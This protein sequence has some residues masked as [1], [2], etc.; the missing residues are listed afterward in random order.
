MQ[1]F[2]KLHIILDKINSSSKK[3][4]ITFL[5]EEQVFLWYVLLEYSSHKNLKIFITKMGWLISFKLYIPVVTRA[6][7]SGTHSSL[8]SHC[9]PL[10]QL[11]LD[12]MATSL[13]DDIFKCIFL[14]ENVRNLIQISLKFVPKGPIDN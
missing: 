6:T 12:K 3:V 1:Y 7:C 9:N 8:S 10:T 5:Y 13:A 14:N 2:L 4:S 11:P